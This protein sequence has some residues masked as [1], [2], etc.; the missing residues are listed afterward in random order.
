MLSGQQDLAGKLVQ[1]F[2]AK[3]HASYVLLLSEARKVFDYGKLV[4]Q[5]K[6]VW[7]KLCGQKLP[8]KV[9]LSSWFPDTHRRA[10]YCF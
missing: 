4:A 2:N 5:T 8:Q 3:D 7:L 9:L 6:V 1:T 10:G